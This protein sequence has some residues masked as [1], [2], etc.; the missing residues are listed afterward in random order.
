M[1][2]LST[3][4]GKGGVQTLG[5]ITT[6]CCIEEGETVFA[7]TLY[8]DQYNDVTPHRQH[9]HSVVVVLVVVAAV[10]E[11]ELLSYNIVRQTHDISTFAYYCCS[12]QYVLLLDI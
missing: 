3:E 4:G 8:I 7:F 1:R 6:Y 2:W 11:E 12:V 10:V 5:R 9:N